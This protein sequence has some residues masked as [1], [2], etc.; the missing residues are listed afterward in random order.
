MVLSIESQRNRGLL[1]KKIFTCISVKIQGANHI[2]VK[3]ETSGV[4]QNIKHK[5]QWQ[6]T[7][8]LKNLKSGRDVIE[9]YNFLIFVFLFFLEKGDKLALTF[10]DSH[11]LFPSQPALTSPHD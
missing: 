4:R 5:N 3:R 8:S 11:G 10:H 2:V 9:I 7:I 6:E 1:S